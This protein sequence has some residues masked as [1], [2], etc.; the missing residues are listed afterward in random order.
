MGKKNTESGATE[1]EPVHIE[2]RDLADYS[3]RIN[4]LGRVVGRGIGYVLIGLSTV[5]SVVA[6]VSLVVWLL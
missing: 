4:K 1:V 3:H 6:I 5:G 2:M